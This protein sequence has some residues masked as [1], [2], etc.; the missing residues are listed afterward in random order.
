MD[1]AASAAKIEKR[2]IVEK[3][4]RGG[5]NLRQR[6]HTAEE[7][8]QN[9]RIAWWSSHLWL[10]AEAALLNLCRCVM[11]LGM[12]LRQREREASARRVRQ[13]SGGGER[14]R[15]EARRTVGQR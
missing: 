12:N 11:M 14:S 7:S 4:V 1:A 10:P 3:V 2:I 9:V 8:A 5:V 15:P 13:S 6:E